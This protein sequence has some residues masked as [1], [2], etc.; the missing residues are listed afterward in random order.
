[1]FDSIAGAVR[2]STQGSGIAASLDLG[3]TYGLAEVFTRGA[4]GAPAD[5]GVY[6]HIWRRGPDHR[7]KL[8]LVVE[9]PL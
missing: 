3:Y 9:N 8:A 1:M 6:L 5:S 7:W 4:S 2:F